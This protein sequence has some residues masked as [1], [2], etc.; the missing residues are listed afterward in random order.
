MTNYNNNLVFPVSQYTKNFSSN[1]SSWMFEQTG[2]MNMDQVKS[3]E[4]YQSCLRSISIRCFEMATLLCSITDS[5][6]TPSSLSENQF[7]SLTKTNFPFTQGIFKIMHGKAANFPKEAYKYAPEDLPSIPISE[8]EPRGVPIYTWTRVRQ[9]LTPRSMFFKKNVKH[10]STISFSPHIAEAI[11]QVENIL[12]LKKNNN[13]EPNEGDE[14]TNPSSASNPTDN[15]S[16]SA[17]LQLP[18]ENDDEPTNSRARGT[19]TASSTGRGRGSGRGGRGRNRGGGN[20]SRKNKSENGDFK[21]KFI[22]KDYILPWNFKSVSHSAEKYVYCNWKPHIYNYYLKNWSYGGVGVSTQIGDFHEG[23]ASKEGYFGFPNV[24]LLNLPK[25]Q[26]FPIFIPVPNSDQHQLLIAVQIID[27]HYDAVALYKFIQQRLFSTFTPMSFK[28]NDGMPF[29]DGI[30][31]KEVF[32]YSI[33]SLAEG[34]EN[35]MYIF[36]ENSRNKSI[37]THPSFFFDFLLSY[38]C[39]SR[40]A[41]SITLRDEIPEMVKKCKE[42]GVDQNLDYYSDINS[43]LN[44]NRLFSLTNAINFLCKDFSEDDRNNLKE[45]INNVIRPWSPSTETSTE[46]VNAHV[47]ATNSYSPSEMTGIETTFCIDT[48]IDNNSNKKMQCYFYESQDFRWCYYSL[49]K[50]RIFGLLNQIMPHCIPLFELEQETHDKIVLKLKEQA[51]RA[52]KNSTSLVPMRVSGGL[53]EQLTKNK[54]LFNLFISGTSRNSNNSVGALM[55]MPQQPKIRWTSLFDKEGRSTFFDAITLRIM[56]DNQFK[57]GLNCFRL[58]IHIIETRVFN[59]IDKLKPKNSLNH[60]LFN[61]M[62]TPSDIKIPQANN[63]DIK[64]KRSKL[65]EIHNQNYTL[66]K[67]EIDHYGRYLKN[68]NS[69]VK[70]L[71]IHRSK[72][73]YF[74]HENFFNPN[75]FGRIEKNMTD[76]WKAVITFIKNL[77][78]ES[79]K[80][81]MFN[82]GDGIINRLD[83]LCPCYYSTMQYG[84]SMRSSV[85]SPCSSF[86]E[87][88]SRRLYE[89]ATLYQNNLCFYAGVF[90]SFSDI[91]KM[92]SRLKSHQWL[93]GSFA[94]GKSWFLFL[95]ESLCIPGVAYP[96]QKSS[97][98]AWSGNGLEEDQMMIA[99]EGLDVIIEDS[100]LV[101][102]ML[103]DHCTSKTVCNH[104][105]ETGE[106]NKK[107]YPGDFRNT[108]VGAHNFVMANIDEAMASR[109]HIIEVLPGGKLLPYIPETKLVDAINDDVKHEHYLHSLTENVV[110]KSYS[111]IHFIYGD[112]QKTK[113]NASHTPIQNHLLFEIEKDFQ[114]LMQAAS[115]I[116]ELKADATMTGVVSSKSLNSNF[117]VAENYDFVKLEATLNIKKYWNYIML[118]QFYMNKLQAVNVINRP[119]EDF[120]S[121][122]RL[123]FKSTFKSLNNGKDPFEANQRIE[124]RLKLLVFNICEWDAIE[125]VFFDE[126]SPYYNIGLTPKFVRAIEFYLSPSFEHFALA[127]SII[128]EELA[129]TTRAKILTC[130]MKESGYWDYTRKLQ[131]TYKIPL[132]EDA[133][134]ADYNNIRSPNF[135]LKSKTIFHTVDKQQ[136]EEDA[137]GVFLEVDKDFCEKTGFNKVKWGSYHEKDILPYIPHSFCQSKITITQPQQQPQPQQSPQPPSHST[138][139]YNTHQTVNGG[140]PTFTPNRNIFNTPAATS[141]PGNSYYVSSNFHNR[142][143]PL[144]P[145]PKT[146]YL[147]V[148][149][150]AL[151]ITYFRSSIKPESLA[152]FLDV[153]FQKHKMPKIGRTFLEQELKKMHET[154]QHNDVVFDLI[155]EDQL[156]NVALTDS[157][158]SLFI[159]R[160]GGYEDDTPTEQTSSSSS[161]TSNH[162]SPNSTK[163]PN[164]VPISKSG[165]NFRDNRILSFKCDRSETKGK[166]EYIIQ[167]LFDVRAM[168]YINE[169][170]VMIQTLETIAFNL[171]LYV[172]RIP[173]L[174]HKAGG[175]LTHIHVGSRLF[176][177]E[178]TKPFSKDKL[179]HIRLDEQLDSYRK[180]IDYGLED[181]DE[182]PHT[183]NP[184]PTNTNNNSSNS[185]NIQ[186]FLISNPYLDINDYFRALHIINGGFAVVEYDEKIS[187]FLVHCPD[188]SSADKIQ[189]IPIE[190]FFD[191]RCRQKLWKK[192]LENNPEFKAFF[193]EQISKNKTSSQTDINNTTNSNTNINQD[194]LNSGTANSILEQREENR[195]FLET[196]IDERKS[197]EDSGEKED[198]SNDG[199]D[200]DEDNL[201]LSSL[202]DKNINNNNQG[203]V[204]NEDDDLQALINENMHYTSELADNMDLDPNPNADYDKPLEKKN[205]KKRPHQ[206]I[207]NNTTSVIEA[208]SQD[209]SSS[210]SL[211]D[212]EDSISRKRKKQKI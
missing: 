56:P 92:V 65:Q 192:Q 64:D 24:P 133:L 159:K 28:S 152:P 59:E 158:Q 134:K 207:S 32:E 82:T 29:F 174:F 128:N 196:I 12:H 151:P 211:L 8:N 136:I 138:S 166:S 76:G 191:S 168:Q 130:I 69:F 169:N 14:E 176:E 188:Y 31:K 205:K 6:G 44:P 165:I 57:V 37:A 54:M 120:Y 38:Y 103:T 62:Y 206:E 20:S 190:K 109:F 175:R 4:D 2:F 153:L 142:T 85:D 42:M 172:T 104:N 189:K 73:L 98:N 135:K 194:N 16:T 118:V 164:F 157:N 63:K 181:E 106:R 11:Y 26:V 143:D 155:R 18:D 67:Q 199:G 148:N 113:L 99:K 70:E 22:P 36:P 79:T 209:S 81:Q 7:D 110:N 48:S 89:Q 202:L 123:R 15:S 105:S 78:D 129:D 33:P 132:K 50:G 77:S 52:K 183:D 47:A 95:L 30:K 49:E 156:Q 41:D 125:R 101:K 13:D 186:K 114:K 91:F 167:A 204:L 68:M 124:D 177:G 39:V 182:T 97:K 55:H 150:V 102:A 193:D 46:A 160:F 45:R 10:Q 34:F 197:T 72:V 58:F 126:D 141:V 171:P 9:N 147:N 3:G 203:N 90:G 137:S 1:A 119:S 93:E 112:L 163:K 17:P 200:N 139:S 208:S 127:A 35:E 111:S 40:E 51:E 53:S 117:A 201:S 210:V 185:P 131:E 145:P 96:V 184:D 198:T 43:D 88:S 122:I 140:D 83:P 170:H 19:R 144:Q 23:D 21:E 74:V 66:S 84:L 87:A 86:L 94:V 100:A 116:Y 75:T 161:Q 187:N 108:L 162:P 60:V 121:F 212:S 179:L 173:L 180:K 115:K 5:V 154:I 71:L 146:H 27:P 25:L 107:V 80:S 149:K 178:N 61:K 195:S